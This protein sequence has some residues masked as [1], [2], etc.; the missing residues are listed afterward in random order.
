MTKIE[1]FLKENS[2]RKGGEVTM[3]ATGT[4]DDLKFFEVALDATQEIR[5]LLLTLGEARGYAYQIA[6]LNAGSN[7]PIADWSQ[8]I[9]TATEKFNPAIEMVRKV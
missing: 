2:L 4:P 1:E 6:V 8:A 5:D 7:K 3:D 9:L